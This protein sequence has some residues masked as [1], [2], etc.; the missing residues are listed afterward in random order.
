[1]ST[2]EDN[3][4]SL[5][6]SSTL[7]SFGFSKKQIILR[8]ECLNEIAKHVSD[9][10]RDLF[11]ISLVGS[12]GEGVKL[13]SS[14]VDVMYTLSDVICVDEGFDN[15]EF[16]ILKSDRSDAAPGYTKVVSIS[17]P[18]NLSYSMIHSACSFEPHTKRTF[19]SSEKL[20]RFISTILEHCMRS[21]DYGY[22][23]EA[24]GPA[25]T[26]SSPDYAAPEV[27]NVMCIYFFGGDYLRKWTDRS[28][29]YTWP[30][31]EVI[32]EISQMEGYIVPVGD[33]QSDMQALE[34]R[35]CYT[36]AEKKLVLGLSDTQIKAYVLLKI[37]AKTLLK[38]KC[39]FLTS[40]IV[41][42][43]IFWVLEM[44]PCHQ[45]SP[46]HLIY[47]I[48]K[49][50]FFIKHCILNNHLPN[51]M[52]PKRNL[53]K[54][55]IFGKRKET[56]VNFLSECLKEGGSIILKIPKLYFCISLKLSKPD[57]VVVHRKWRDEVEL[58]ELRCRKYMMN[59][60]TIK[61][62]MNLFSLVMPDAISLMMSGK[63][64]NDIIHLFDERM[65]LV[66]I[67]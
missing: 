55:K 24:N 41:K 30:S 2:R 37:M 43:V 61:T 18:D 64:D 4:L 52:I 28:R 8:S 58:C 66:N 1:M 40:Y 17:K 7:D 9:D 39:K 19:I 38:S 15:K 34:W 63:T 5:I 67:L 16:I 56:I 22:K 20:K 31:Q 10:A 36:T 51:Y 54:G 44:T 26:L 59:D 49:S 53:L 45:L 27:D 60:R 47:L 35:I 33:K 42:N 14:D 29:M 3:E 57:L 32:K 50:L 11:T 46:S 23:T 13:S 6:I 65:K 62:H 25:E 48:Q 12:S 21:G